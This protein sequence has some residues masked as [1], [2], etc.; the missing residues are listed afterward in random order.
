[1]GTIGSYARATIN[2]TTD[3]INLNGI[4]VEGGLI[5]K[6][7]VGDYYA[8]QG[9]APCED[10]GFVQARTYDGNLITGSASIH[11]GYKSGKGYRENGGNAGSDTYK[12]GGGAGAYG[13]D[14]PL[15]G[16]TGGGGGGSGYSN[17][18][19]TL[20]TSDTLPTG[21]RQ[22]G[23]DDTAFISIEATSVASDNEPVIPAASS[24]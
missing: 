11:R 18:E 2:E 20:L 14:A 24:L 13:G 5:P 7:T 21:T 12:G 3:I 22:G 8:Q 9:Y 19:V 1:M 17:G 15:V 23:N 16:N 4:N 6:C 10:L